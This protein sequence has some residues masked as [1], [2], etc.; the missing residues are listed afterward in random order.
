MNRLKRRVRG[1]FVIVIVCY[2]MQTKNVD[3]LFVGPESPDGP[4]EKDR[5]L[6]DEFHWKYTP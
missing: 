6:V 2:L 4:D 5:V 3:E 1:A